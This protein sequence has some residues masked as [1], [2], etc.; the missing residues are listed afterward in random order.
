[1]ANGQHGGYRQPANPAPV[2]GPGALSQ[3]T[4]GGPGAQPVRRLP[5]ADYGENR[6]FVAQQEGAPLAQAEPIDPSGL[7][8]MGAPSQHP[9]MPV[10]AGAVTPNAPKEPGE[11]DILRLRDYFGVMKV[12]ASRPEASPATKQLVRQLEARMGQ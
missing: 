6:D 3:R 12:L 9:E 11:E 7:T 8:P 1:M 5:D 2:S 10:T 4:D